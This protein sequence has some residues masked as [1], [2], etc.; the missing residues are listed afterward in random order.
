MNRLPTRVTS[1]PI[2]EQKHKP[3][4]DLYLP[5]ALP[6]LVGQS[7]IE[8]YHTSLRLLHSLPAHA[9]FYERLHRIEADLVRKEIEAAGF[10]FEA[11]SNILFDP[12]DTLDWKIFSSDHGGQDTTSRF[13]Y[14]FRK[15]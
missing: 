13:V 8:V 6:F 11:E 7:L 12:E 10:V 1:F 5:F 4:L 2:V 3:L 14:L 15:P 9:A